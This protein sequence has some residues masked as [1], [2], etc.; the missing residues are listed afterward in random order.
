MWSSLHAARGLA[1]ACLVVFELAE[2]ECCLSRVDEVQATWVQHFPIRC[3]DQRRQLVHRLHG[4]K[5]Q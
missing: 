4:R 3:V 1:G 2:Q 5:G